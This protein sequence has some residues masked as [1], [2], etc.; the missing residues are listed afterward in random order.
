MSQSDAADD[1]RTHLSQ[2]HAWTG[3]PTPSDLSELPNGPAIYLLVDTGGAAVQLATTQTL[4]RLLVSRLTD[5]QRQ[6]IGKADLAEIA[7]GVRWRPLATAF[8]GRWWYYR[9]ARVMHPKEYRR[10]ISFGP[11]YFLNVDWTQPVPELCVTERVWD[12]PGEFIGPWPAHKACHTALEG[13]WDLYD[14]CRYPEQV[15]KAPHGTRCAYAEMG[16]CDAP[17]DGST[18][19]ATYVGRCRAAWQFAVG[20]VAEWI[21]VAEQ[22]MRAAAEQQKYELAGLIKQQ[23]RFARNWQSQWVPHVRPVAELNYLFVLPIVRRRAWKLILFRAGHLADGPIVPQRRIG[24]DARAWLAA[25]LGQPCEDVPD[26]VRMEQTWLVC[27]LLSSREA[28][29]SV[30]LAL[31]Q[32]EM[33][34]DL[35]E[36][37]VARTVE[38]RRTQTESGDRATDVSSEN[39]LST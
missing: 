11:A 28:D 15:R 39:E 1:L 27:H 34:A 10:L 14:L 7:R 18:A 21:S 16:R 32:L 5:P 13:L 25:Q 12:Q 35:E 36:T 9:L 3:R 22:R 20:G 8:E 2:S 23:L 4:R 6:Q 17:C 19:L 29:S 38:R 30:I 26:S 37:L 24:P 31:P 33:P